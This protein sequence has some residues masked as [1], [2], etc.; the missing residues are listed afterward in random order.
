MSIDH[1]MPPLLTLSEDA[2]ETLKTSWGVV[3]IAHGSR[4]AE[5]NADLE[6]L[7]D[8]FRSLGFRWVVASFLELADPDIVGGAEQCLALGAPRLLLA[9][10]FLS[11]GRHVVQD[12]EDARQQIIA[13]HPQL[14]CRLAGPLG[15]HPLLETI[16]IERMGQ[17]MDSSSD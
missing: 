2:L 17:V 14:D 15:P 8:Q 13:N 7:A 5:A 4:R 3:L 6:E 11:A 12:L 9:P 16:L 1:R 10:Y